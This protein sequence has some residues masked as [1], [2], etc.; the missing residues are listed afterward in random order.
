M[1][2]GVSSDN[3]FIV[4][5]SMALPVHLGPWSL[6]QFVIIFHRVGDE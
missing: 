6:I 5:I 1:H 3:V 2:G 4:I